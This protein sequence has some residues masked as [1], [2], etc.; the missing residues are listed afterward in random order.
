MRTGMQADPRSGAGRRV[1]E[2]AAVRDIM[3]TDVVSATPQTTVARIA[4]LMNAR[5][6]SGLPVV[7]D[8]MRVVG[9]VTDFD[10]IVRNT[11]IE[12]PPF[13]PLLEGRI[14]LETPNHFRKRVRRMAGLEARDIMTPEVVVIGPD[15]D[16]EHLADL[17]VK[18]GISVVPVVERGR[19]AGVVSRA[20]IVRWM[21]RG[22]EPLKEKS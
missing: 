4:Q 16:I 13:L 6:I 12:P 11:R 5:A 20:D 7:D 19:L 14:P 21:T 9:I 3:T 8:A 18:A 1:A 17:M 2:A 10:L 15:D 22:Q